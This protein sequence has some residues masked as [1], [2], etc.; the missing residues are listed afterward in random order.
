[1]RFS[2]HPFPRWMVVR[3]IL[4]GLSAACMSATFDSRI[5]R[6]LVRPAAMAQRLHQS[7]RRVAQMQ[8]DGSCA[9][10]ATTSSCTA[11]Y[12][13]YNASDFSR[14]CRINHLLCQRRGSIP[15]RQRNPLHRGGQRD[16]PGA[17]DQRGRYL[18]EPCGPRAGRSARMRRRLDHARQPMFERRIR[19]AVAHALVQ[20]GDEV[21]VFFA[22]LV[23]SEE[24]FCSASLTISSVMQGLAP[25]SAYSGAR[26]VGLLARYRH[27]QRRR[28][29]RP[30]SSAARRGRLRFR[31]PSSRSFSWS[32]RRC[33]GMTIGPPSAD[34]AR[35]RGSA[36]QR[37]DDL[38]R[39]V[40]RGCA[41]QA[42]TSLLDVGR[43]ASCCAL[44]KRWTSSTKTMVRVPYWRGTLRVGHDLLD[45]FYAGRARLRIR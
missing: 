13:V 33:R 40:L 1:M 34:S 9:D 11:A 27:C 19:I 30:R 7:R 23:V 41:D 26:V 29:N 25:P 6:V 22:G 17:F 3:A 37:R 43:K 8:P 18:R 5:L 31:S 14:H 35:T 20:R 10:P 38:E 21:V 12:A 44:L 42:N 16:D 36:R 28:W 2:R 32:A 4:S 15:A 45:F 24:R 39:R